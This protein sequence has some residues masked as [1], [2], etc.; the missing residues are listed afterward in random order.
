MKKFSFILFAGVIG[1]L[2]SCGSKKESGGM[3]D[4]AKKN[5]K[6][7]RAICKML[8]SGDWSQVGDGSAGDAGD[9]GSSS[10]KVN[11]GLGSIKAHFIMNCKMMGDMKNE[12]VKASA[13]D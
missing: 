11:V 13:D 2:V 6:A 10:G 12:I 4:A 3:S 9:Q 8:E 1:L 5:L 7:N